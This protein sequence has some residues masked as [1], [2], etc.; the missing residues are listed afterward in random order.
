VR[1]YF[2]TLKAL[3]RGLQ[4]QTFALEDAGIIPADKEEPRLGTAE[5]RQAI[6]PQRAADDTVTNGGLGNLDVAWLNSRRR[7]VGIGKEQ[8][9]RAEANAWLAGAREVEDDIMEDVKTES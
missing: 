1:T 2:T 6:E 3:E 9:L 8:E 7:D 4:K 5:Q